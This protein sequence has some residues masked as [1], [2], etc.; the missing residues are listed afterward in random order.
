MPLMLRFPTLY[1]A[2]VRLYM[3]RGNVLV[4]MRKSCKVFF[5]WKF[6]N[7]NIIHVKLIK[8]ILEL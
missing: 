5:D 1:K 2:N 4:K 7:D 8:E 6:M 3:K